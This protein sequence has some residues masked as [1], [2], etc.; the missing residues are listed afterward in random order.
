MKQ[1]CLTLLLSLCL[2]A[3]ASVYAVQELS[4]QW[5]VKKYND[6][7]PR[8]ELKRMDRRKSLERKLKRVV[9]DYSDR[10]KIFTSTGKAKLEDYRKRDVAWKYLPYAGEGYM[11]NVNYYCGASGKVCVPPGT[12]GR[13]DEPKMIQGDDYTYKFGEKTETYTNK[14]PNPKYGKHEISTVKF[15][16]KAKQPGGLPFVGTK[17]KMSGNEF[18]KYHDYLCKGLENC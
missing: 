16:E 8:F 5:N 7:K 11:Y 18:W 17:E 6:G 12:N 9:I 14:Y 15:T 4:G 13:P 3:Q 10:T 1:L 2:P